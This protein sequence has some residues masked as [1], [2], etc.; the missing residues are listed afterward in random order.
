MFFSCSKSK[1]EN[2]LTE[3]EM[4]DGWQLLFDGKTLNGWHLYNN[5]KQPI[6]WVVKD[7]VLFCDP[8]N[9]DAEHGDLL[10]DKAYT[11]FEFTFEWKLSDGGNSGIF[12]NVQERDSIPTAWASG[13]EY[14][15]LDKSHH[16][17]E[18]T[19][20]RSGCLY[21][22]ASQKNPVEPKENH[23]WNQSTIKQINGKVEFYLNGVLTAEQD[24]TT[25][26]WTQKVAATGFKNFPEFGKYT[27]GHIALQ[28]WNKG[29]SFRNIK[30]KEL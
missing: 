19:D 26:E 3:S 7:G 23:D 21:G 25:E 28:D 16:D 15:L 5:E 29:V 18:K 6:A 22:F 24:F 20:K 2:E 11:N 9:V 10:T 17:Y 4:A 12:I 30:I 1:V 8:A 13:P 27:S 14:Q